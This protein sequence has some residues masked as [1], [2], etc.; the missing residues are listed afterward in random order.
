MRVIGQYRSRAGRP[1]VRHQDTPLRYPYHRV[2][3]YLCHRRGIDDRPELQTTQAKIQAGPGRRGTLGLS[4][5]PLIQ[6]CPAHCASNT[7]TTDDT[8]TIRLVGISMV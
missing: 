8:T 1:Y 7:I 4:I 3:A 6:G 2:R 5:P